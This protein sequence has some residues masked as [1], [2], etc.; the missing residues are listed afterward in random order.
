MRWLAM[1]ELPESLQGFMKGKDG[2]S[3]VRM[4][5]VCSLD[6][7]IWGFSFGLPGALNDL[8]ILEVSPHFARVLSGHFLYVSPS[9]Q[10][11]EITID[12]F[13]YLTDGIY[14]WWKIFIKSLSEASDQKTKMFSRTKEGVRTCVK[15]VFGV[16]PAV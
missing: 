12:W 16:V 9:Y 3:E 11:A 10:I 5:V 6:L 8:I 7:W 1:E 2:R 4:E 13:Y 15:S 14:P